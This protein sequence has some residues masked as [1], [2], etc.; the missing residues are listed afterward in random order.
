MAGVHDQIFKELI[1][2]F[3]KNFLTL[4]MPDIASRID[5]GDVVFEPGDYFL[6][7]PR[8]KRRA[9][10]LIAQVR[11]RAS[12][13]EEAVIHIEIEYAFR[14]ARVVRI[15]EYNRLLAMRHELPVH[16]VVIYLHGGQPG[17]RP[18]EYREVSLERELTVFRYTSW[19]LSRTPAPAYLARPEPLA[20]AFAALMHPGSLGSRTELGLA[21]LRRIAAVRDL[22]EVRR[23]RLFNCVATHIELDTRATEEYETL[24]RRSEN[25]EVQKMMMTWADRIEAKGRAAG[26]DE[27]HKEG[28][29]EG[30]KGVYDLVLHLLSQRFGRVPAS[31]KRRIEAISSVQELTRLA[32]SVLKVDSLEELGLGS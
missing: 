5:L 29:A 19:G 22:D 27:G 9:P 6:D 23:F 13:C 2:D 12:P 10:D 32:E 1:A 18:V 17:I 20:W 14:Q 3:P 25:L 4:V 16:S 7:S 11:S 31:I 30:R 15:P 26:R 24:L 8:G 28:L 21:C